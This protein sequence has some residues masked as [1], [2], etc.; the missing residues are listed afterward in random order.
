MPGR[1]AGLLIAAAILLAAAVGSLFLNLKRFNES[2]DVVE[3]TNDVLHE[4]AR[5]ETALLRAESGERGYILSG[6][7]SYLESY[8]AASEDVHHALDALEHLV[9]DNPAQAARVRE[10]RSV[11][12]ARLAEFA[13]IV[14]L[15][16]THREAALALLGAARVQQRT[17][18]V[19]AMMEQLRATEQDLLKER[20]ERA[21]DVAWQMT[22]FAMAMTVL[23]V[24]GTGF[25]AY[26]LERQRTMA[27]LHSV[28]LRSA[29]L[30]SELLHVSRLSNMGEMASDL[31]H[32]LNQPLTALA[33][34]IQG[35]RRLLEQ[36]PGD[37]AEIVKGALA[38][39]AE[40]TLR[41][42]EVIRRLREFVARGES[43]KRVESLRALVEEAASLA[44]LVAK[45]QPVRLSLVLDPAVDEVLVDRIQI[46]QVL[47]NLMR[48]GI[49]AMKD[50]PRRDLSVAS[51]GTAQGMVAVMVADTGSG[52]DAEVAA[53]LF[54][55]FRTTK[56]HGLGVGL[57]ISRTIVEAHGGQIGTLAN[58][59]GGT[60]FRFTLPS[61][62]LERAGGMPPNAIS[63]R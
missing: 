50:T 22:A 54:Q 48:N 20:A 37:K 27:Q 18:L 61:A 16:A 63:G 5:A 44:L 9:T 41:A 7:A 33:S 24:L 30:Q 3:H 42:G 14:A 39:A 17:E 52:I 60:I 19:R 32:E 6:N 31:A 38:K 12:E 56:P 36:I 23:A 29:E 35:S 2:Y 34:Y 43:V 45:E 21:D 59:G 40:Q 13:Q 47:L 57:S 1:V 49:E 25:G 26:L 51:E 10:M 15:G 53:T 55:P 58:P 46:Q 28:E 4:I 11:A 8:Q 62:A